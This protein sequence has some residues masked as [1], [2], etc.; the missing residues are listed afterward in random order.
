MLV[1]EFWEAKPAKRLPRDRVIVEGNLVKYILWQSEIAVWNR[2]M[3]TLTI[4]DCG[5]LTQ[6]TMGR[7]NGIISCLD[8]WISSHRRKWIISRR[9]GAEYV[10]AGRHII[11]L[12]SGE[13]YPAQPR[14]LMPKISRSLTRYYS[15]LKPYLERRML[16]F[17]TLEGDVYTFL[18][19]YGKERRILAI[20]IPSDSPADYSAWLAWIRVPTIYSSIANPAR[21]LT[22]VKREGKEVRD[23]D[24]IIDTLREMRFPDENIPN[25][26][27]SALALAKILA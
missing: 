27:L 24:E 1:K 10:W 23:P 26:V 15:A 16:R 14:R 13:I 4:S 7:L 6:L 20:R 21:L 11:Y 18:S 9:N 3:H 17:R 8:Y 19:E 25:R 5:W 2:L 12:D 22:A